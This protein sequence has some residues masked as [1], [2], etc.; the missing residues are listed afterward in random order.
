MRSRFRLAHVSQLVRGYVYSGRA[1]LHELRVSPALAQKLRPVAFKVQFF[2]PDP[3][4]LVALPERSGI[5]TIAYDDGLRGKAAKVNLNQGRC[6]RLMGQGTV[7]VRNLRD[8][9]MCNAPAANAVV[10][11]AS[12]RRLALI[13]EC[14]V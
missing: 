10:S 7:T 13:S 8:Y 1:D 14:A 2:G 9:I 4:I 6:V 5:A 3:E 12:V 11:C